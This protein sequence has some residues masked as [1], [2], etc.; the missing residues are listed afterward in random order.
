M[1]GAE[2]S[3][4]LLHVPRSASSF[5]YCCFVYFERRHLQHIH[6]DY[7]HLDYKTTRGIYIRNCLAQQLRNTNWKRR[8]LVGHVQVHAD[9]HASTSNT[10][11]SWL[12]NAQRITHRY[13]LSRVLYLRAR[14]RSRPGICTPTAT[15]LAG[16]REVKIG[17][18][19][20][21]KAHGREAFQASRRAQRRLPVCWL[22]G[23]V[24]TR[25]FLLGW[26]FWK[27]LPAG[28]LPHKRRVGSRTAQIQREALHTDTHTSTRTPVSAHAAPSSLVGPGR[29][30]RRVVTPASARARP[31]APAISAGRSAG[32]RT[33]SEHS[34]KRKKKKGEKKKKKKEPAPSPP[35]V[36]DA[37]AQPGLEPIFP[38]GGGRRAQAG[39]GI[40]HLKSTNHEIARPSRLR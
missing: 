20:G 19:R 32:T 22:M 26:N 31:S 15:L 18:Q 5:Y 28:N 7:T 34:K 13:E 39:T 4:C 3:A 10:C 24:S 38:R 2:P 6:L 30:E 35:P 14:S 21:R 8:L 1:W 29:K 9:A 27:G 11:S 16:C 25:V 40:C 12:Q 23:K 33:P 17:N 36:S 37:R